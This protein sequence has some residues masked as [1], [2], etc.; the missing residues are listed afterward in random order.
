MY[1]SGGDGIGGVFDG[2]KNEEGSN[3]NVFELYMM[4]YWIYSLCLGYHYVEATFGNSFPTQQK[5]LQGFSPD[6]L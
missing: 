4:L 1:R 5:A 6:N 3:L 2:P